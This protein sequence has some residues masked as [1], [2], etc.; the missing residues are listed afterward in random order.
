MQP[1]EFSPFA[2]ECC[3]SRSALENVFAWSDGS[4]EL[5][6]RFDLDGLLTNVA[7][8]WFSGNVAATLRIYEENARR[9]PLRGTR[10]VSGIGERHP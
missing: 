2:A 7:V 3:A 8:Y 1:H 10:A 9:R 6:Q 4:D 5:T